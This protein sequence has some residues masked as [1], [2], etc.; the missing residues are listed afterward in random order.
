LLVLIAV[1]KREREREKKKE[2]KMVHYFLKI[3]E[4]C[5]FLTRYMKFVI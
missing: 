3:Y 4:I 1:N 2:T 5:L